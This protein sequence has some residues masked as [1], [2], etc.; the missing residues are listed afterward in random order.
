MAIFIG[1]V[2]RTAIRFPAVGTEVELYPEA[3]KFV[4]DEGSAWA[5]TEFVGWLAPKRQR[6]LSIIVVLSD[7][8]G[9][10]P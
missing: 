6:E 4:D 10:N 9:R 2:T 3:L 1:P 7:N 5:K 8:N